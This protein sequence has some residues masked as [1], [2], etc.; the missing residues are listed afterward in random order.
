MRSLRFLLF[1]LR[2]CLLLFGFLKFLPFQGYVRREPGL[3]KRYF[4]VKFILL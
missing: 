1:L 2:F 4:L 3:G